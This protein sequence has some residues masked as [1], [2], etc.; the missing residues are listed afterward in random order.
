MHF[1]YIGTAD[2][3]K[4]ALAPG[5]PCH[6]TSALVVD[7]AEVQ[8]AEEEIDALCL[9]FFGDHARDP[10]VTFDGP[11]IHAGHGA[12][13][14]L[15]PEMR[16]KLLD[17]LISILV[18]HHARIGYGAIEAP[19][20]PPQERALGFLVGKIGDYF[21][22]DDKFGLL[23]AGDPALAIDLPPSNRI[24]DGLH[25]VEPKNSRLSQ[26][27]DLA[28]CLLLRGIR[29]GRRLARDFAGISAPFNYHDWLEHHASPDE[30]AE[31]HLYLRLEQRLRFWKI[32]PEAACE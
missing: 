10:A 9:R 3:A 1:I 7:A 29:N 5:R 31:D 30:V 4:A 18:H 25:L 20:E 14:V 13:A 11:D 19:D 15:P 27:A 17:G 28:A 22:L 26:M 24:I 21:T 8:A 12:F 32:F 2:A 23:I 16:H 6:L